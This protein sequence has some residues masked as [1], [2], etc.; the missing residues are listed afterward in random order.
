M[1]PLFKL[2]AG[3]FKDS[4][5]TRH[6][7]LRDAYGA[8]LFHWTVYARKPTPAQVGDVTVSRTRDKRY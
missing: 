2:D 5:F 3:D 4:R 6:H 7:K 8:G 1:R